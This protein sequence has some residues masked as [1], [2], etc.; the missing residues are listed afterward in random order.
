MIRL[1]NLT[2]IYPKK[3]TAL[4]SINLKIEKGEFVSI[5]GKSGAG[6][7]TLIRLILREEVATK[8]EINVFDWKVHSLPNR[9]IPFYRRNLG[10]VFQDYKIL[11]QKNIFENIAFPLEIEGLPKSE[12]QKRTKEILDLI[13]LS[14]K[15]LCFS[16]ELSGGELQAACIGRALINQ[17]K[18]L[19]ADEPTGNL[20]IIS[21]QRIIE[22][23]SKINQTGTTILLASH[24]QE[25][26]NSLNSR[27]ITLE[28][29][30][31]IRDE[32]KGNY[33]L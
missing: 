22:L 12:I 26:V 30:R 32:K 8:G 24:N 5:I 14:E 2:K 19:L 3:I 10:V 25:I 27:V 21:S 9:K 4:S 29:G 13:G 11:P 23:F 1:V 20:D 6:K 17:P 28:K 31:I 33:R 7:S 16:Q 15:A 18:V